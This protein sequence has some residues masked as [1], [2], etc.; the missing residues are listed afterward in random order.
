MRAARASP[1]M[2]HDVADSGKFTEVQGGTGGSTSV[3]KGADG[4]E[5]SRRRLTAARVI[6]HREGVGRK[7]LWRKYVPITDP[8]QSQ[9]NPSAR[10]SIPID[11][12]AIPRT[13]WRTGAQ[14]PLEN[15]VEGGVKDRCQR[16]RR[17]PALE[18]S[19]QGRPRQPLPNSPASGDYMPAE[20]SPPR[21]C[22]WLS[23]PAL[24]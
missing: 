14:A 17:P 21:H 4:G 5:A 18:T 9:K 22:W 10:A 2:T 7:P 20:S 11:Q 12:V 23:L 3:T 13:L 19:N 8:A 6:C 16:R 15:G 24:A 1:P